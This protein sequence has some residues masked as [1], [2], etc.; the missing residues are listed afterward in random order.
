MNLFT[1]ELI[2]R[3]D[4]YKNIDV[5]F[6]NIIKEINNSLGPNRT[7]HEDGGQCF[8]NGQLSVSAG[9]TLTSFLDCRHT[10]A[11]GGGVIPELF[12]TSKMSIY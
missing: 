9:F 11:G 2:K 6:K 3:E 8:Q 12:S 7:Q 4:Q 5:H 10:P 1:C